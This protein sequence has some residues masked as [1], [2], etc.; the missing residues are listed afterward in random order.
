MPLSHVRA[1]SIFSS[2]TQVSKLATPPDMLNSSLKQQRLKLFCHFVLTRRGGPVSTFSSSRSGR[3]NLN[4]DGA[5]VDMSDDD[6]DSRAGD[7]NE[8]QTTNAE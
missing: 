6:A 8:T 4:L 2:H 1:V 7:F 5:S 3:R